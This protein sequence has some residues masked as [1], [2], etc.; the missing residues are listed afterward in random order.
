LLRSVGDL[1]TEAGGKLCGGLLNKCQRTIAV[2]IGDRFVFYRLRR[3]N[4]STGCH[5]SVGI[6]ARRQEIANRN[7]C[8]SREGMGLSDPPP[9]VLLCALLGENRTGDSH[10]FKSAQTN[11]RMSLGRSIVSVSPSLSVIAE[12]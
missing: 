7:R 3:D 10:Q 8:P 2:H 9:S 1:L 5:N 12:P 4:R 11:V 6:R